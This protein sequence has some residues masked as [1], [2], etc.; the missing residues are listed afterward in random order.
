MTESVSVSQTP[1]EIRGEGNHENSLELLAGDTFGVRL[2]YFSDSARIIG[3]GADSV[4]IVGSDEFDSHLEITT[5]P[6]SLSTNPPVINLDIVTFSATFIDA[7]SATRYDAHIMI[8]GEVDVISISEPVFTMADNGSLVSWDWNFKADKARDG[9]YIVFISLCYGDENDFKATGEYHLKF[10]KTEGD[11]GIIE[12]LGLI[13]PLIII[14]IIAVV[15]IVVVRKIL[16]RR[17]ERTAT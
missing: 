8:D 17:A 2:A 15:I 4:L 9:D 5:S 3:P 6:M 14:A 13:F 16:S 1:T 11:P 12:S 7:F 10:E